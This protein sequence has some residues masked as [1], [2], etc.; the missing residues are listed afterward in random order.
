MTSIKEM[1]DKQRRQAVP[2]V[3]S[4]STHQSTHLTRTRAGTTAVMAHTTETR[5]PTSSVETLRLGPSTS[6]HTVLMKTNDGSSNCITKSDDG[7]PNS[8][9]GTQFMQ[10]VPVSLEDVNYMPPCRTTR[11]DRTQKQV[12][13]EYHYEI[14]TVHV[15]IFLPTDIYNNS[16]GIYSE[17]ISFIK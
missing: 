15:Y 12:E 10:L 1:F 11:N 16:H 17:T 4:R 3:P 13:Y 5:R 9:I 6:R 2:V 7:N 8:R 14:G